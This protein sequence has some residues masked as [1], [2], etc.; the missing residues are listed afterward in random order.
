M[1]KTWTR[2]VSILEEREEIVPTD[3]TLKG[4]LKKLINKR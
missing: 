1:F 4:F 2:D 3:N